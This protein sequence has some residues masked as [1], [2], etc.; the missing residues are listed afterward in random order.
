MAFG[1]EAPLGLTSQLDAVNR[2]L[3]AIW[4]TPVSS[5]DVAGVASVAQAKRTLD[6]TMRAV[7]TRGWAFNTEYN[8]TLNPDVNGFIYLP[9]NTLEVDSW[10]VDADRDVV[11]RGTRLYDRD[12]HTFVFTKSISVMVILMLEW[13]EL[14]E[15]ARHYIAVY[16]AR[17]FADSWLQRG[18]SSQVSD[19]EKLALV[20]LEEHEAQTEDANM[21]TDSWSV[22]GILQR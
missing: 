9:N 4:E 18:E 12:N 13:D 20:N 10:G 17:A 8:Y 6:T 21:F 3:E 11:Q 22:A 5:L 1:V 7:Q 2:C 16:A 19:E 15:A 14:P